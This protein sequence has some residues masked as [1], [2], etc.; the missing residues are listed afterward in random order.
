MKI[1]FTI[2]LLIS[3]AFSTSA[4]AGAASDLAE[5]LFKRIFSSEGKIATQTVIKQAIKDYTEKCESSSINTA[6]KK[7]LIDCIKVEDSYKRCIDK[8]IDENKNNF[9]AIEFCNSADLKNY[10]EGIVSI[11]LGYLFVGILYWVAFIMILVIAMSLYELTKKINAM[12]WLGTLLT[13][14]GAFM[15]AI[16]VDPLNIYL[17]N[18]GAFFWLIA[19]IRIKDA[20]LIVLNGSL[21]IIN[22]L[23]VIWRINI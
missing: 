10:E 15:S 17:F 14:C 19:S 16:E 7:P 21:L 18:G 12:K 23:G 2:V 4:S 1:K 6:S 11:V 9:L 20:S 22:I 5:M 3:L 8:Q 13:L